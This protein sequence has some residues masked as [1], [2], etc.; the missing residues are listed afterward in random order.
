MI[1]RPKNYLHRANERPKVSEMSK[2]SDV[3]SDYI[4]IKY[5]INSYIYI[6]IYICMYVY[7][8]CNYA[9]NA[10]TPKVP[11][12]DK[13]FMPSQSV[14]NLFHDSLREFVLGLTG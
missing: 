8:Y 9:I 5:R 4:Y 14:V 13:E 6:Y 12:A 10:E 1:R 7:I 2:S 11:L 3:L